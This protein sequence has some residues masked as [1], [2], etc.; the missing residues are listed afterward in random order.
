MLWSYCIWCLFLSSLAV[1]NQEKSSNPTLELAEQLKSNFGDV[2]YKALNE[3]G[4][5]NDKII[6]KPKRVRMSDVPYFDILNRN[7]EFRRKII[8]PSQLPRQ[9]KE[10]WE[11]KKVAKP[12]YSA[13]KSTFAHEEPDAS[14]K[15]EKRAKQLHYYGPEFLK[16]LGI[17]YLSKTLPE[18]DIENE[19][20][21]MS[22]RSLK[23]IELEESNEKKEDEKTEAPELSDPIPVPI[24][25][26]N[27]DQSDN[28]DDEKSGDGKKNDKKKMKGKKK[29]Q[30]NTEANRYS[31]PAFAQ[32]THPYSLYSSGHHPGL[33]SSGI[34]N[35]YQQQLVGV[36]PTIQSTFVPGV[37]GTN[38]NIG[39][40]SGVTHVAVNPGNSYQLTYPLSY[41]NYGHHS[42][43][44]ITNPTFGAVGFA[45]SASISGAALGNTG[46]PNSQSIATPHIGN[47]GF[48]NIASSTYSNSGFSSSSYPIGNGFPSNAFSIPYYG[49]PNGRSA[50]QKI[51]SRKKKKK[52]KNK[53]KGSTSVKK[54]V[55]G[56]LAAGI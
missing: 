40:V 22:S 17:S 38:G 45:S 13:E 4:L 9:P 49:N 39:S 12:K 43:N 26:S 6:E 44:L 41:N 15:S 54:V 20:G 14:N 35:P 42:S 24:S 30:S 37:I 28:N 53:K 5:K 29:N 55:G 34:I 25:T 23:D 19:N 52:S 50:T 31:Q 56:A 2:I 10:R 48:S 8:S 1:S 32:Y 7:R 27:P 18:K 36:G 16:L 33:V 51:E 3:D 11:Q 47:S 46:F 21:W